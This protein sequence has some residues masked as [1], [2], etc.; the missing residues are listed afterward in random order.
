V[1]CGQNKRRVELQSFLLDSRVLCQNIYH[2]E[3]YLEQMQRKLSE[4]FIF[5]TF[6]LGVRDGVVG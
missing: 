4:Y 5:D 1:H 2:R 6:L 3:K